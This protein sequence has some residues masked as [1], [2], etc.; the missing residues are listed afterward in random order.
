MITS[1]TYKTYNNKIPE[2][3]IKDFNYVVRSIKQ[4]KN[5]Q[6][7]NFYCDPRFDDNDFKDA[8]HLNYLGA[9]KFSGIVRNHISRL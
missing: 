3:Y 1:P 8:G 5:L 7:Y 6:Y 2:S 4:N 9:K